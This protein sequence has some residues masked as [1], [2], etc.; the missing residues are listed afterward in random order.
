MCT[1]GIDM[2]MQQDRPATTSRTWSVA[3]D[4][5][6]VSAMVAGAERHAGILDRRAPAQ[7]SASGSMVRTHSTPM[8]TCA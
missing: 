4:M 8:P 1:C 7:A 6:K 3:G 2:A 5:R